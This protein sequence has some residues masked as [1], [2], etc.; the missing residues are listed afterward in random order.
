MLLHTLYKVDSKGKVRTFS[1]EVDGDKFRA[2]TGLKEGK[3]TTSAWTVCTPKNIGKSNETTGETQAT[4]EVEAKYVK[5][6]ASHYYENEEDALNTPTQFFKTML[7]SVLKKGEVEKLLEKHGYLILDPKLDGMRMAS[8]K[9]IKHSRNG[10]PIPSVNF[11]ESE[12]TKFHNHFPNII[13]DGE[14]YNH[15]YSDDFNE[16]M[17]M[18]RKDKPNIER[19]AKIQANVQYHVYDIYDETDVSM[20]CHD[21]KTWIDRNLG[22]FVSFSS[23]TDFIKIVKW[24]EVHNMDEYNAAIEEHL[25]DGYEGSI[26]RIPTAVYKNGRSKDL[27]KV[28][29]FITEEFTIIDIQTGKGNNAGMAGRIIVKGPTGEDVGCGIR[30]GWA[31]RKELLNTRYKLIGKQATIRHFG[32]TIDGSLRFPVCIDV[33]RDKYE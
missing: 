28:K 1:I 21:R 17:S 14:L 6:L 29:E 12:L 4:L 3:Q 18:V 19:A 2:I 23:N 24:K 25:A 8:R 15:N 27:I 9:A 10:K 16:L 31:Y 30:G 13:L 33:D 11:M 22:T 26:I 32:Q 7:A 5:K 20:F